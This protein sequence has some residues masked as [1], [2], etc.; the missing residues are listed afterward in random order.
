MC[1]YTAACE[2]TLYSR[3][4][5]ARWWGRAP[6]ATPGTHVCT[7]LADARQAPLDNLRTA[8]GQVSRGV[9]RRGGSGDAPCRGHY[10]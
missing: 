8:W 2:D 4:Q 5:T 1:T 9:A 7:L 6:G 10:Y 3:L